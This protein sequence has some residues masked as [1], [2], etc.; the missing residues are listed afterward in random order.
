MEAG[1]ITRVSPDS[2]SSIAQ[3]GSITIWVSTGKEKVAVPNI[4]AGTK[5]ATAELMLKAVGLKAQAN[6][7]ADPTA[8]V[9]GID[10]VAGAQVDVGSTVTIT[11][12]AGSTGGGTGTGDGGNGTGNG[13]GTG[14]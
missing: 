11:T 4:A 7:P 14:E 13:G 8:V 9:V 5:Y 2:G 12:K 3:G 10:P 1:L 6:G